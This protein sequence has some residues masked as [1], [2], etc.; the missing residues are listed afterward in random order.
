VAAV[1]VLGVPLAE[2]PMPLAGAASFARVLL[3]IVLALGLRG[4]A[5]LKMATV[6]L[7]QLFT[8]QITHDLS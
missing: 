6:H 3:V 8:R 4:L 5:A 1:L 2:V 7:F